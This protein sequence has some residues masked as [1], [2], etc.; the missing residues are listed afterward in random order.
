MDIGEII[1]EATESG[2]KLR[3]EMQAIKEDILA[4]DSQI[5]EL[6]EYTI[7]DEE[8]IQNFLDRHHLE[9]EKSIQ[10]NLNSI[11][12]LGKYILLR[13]EQNKILTKLENRLNEVFN[14]NKTTWKINE[15]FSNSFYF[16][17]TSE[18]GYFETMLIKYKYNSKKDEFKFI[19]AA[20]PVG[21]DVTLEELKMLIEK[22][23]YENNNLCLDK[24]RSDDISFNYNGMEIIIRKV[25]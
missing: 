11:I 5:E 23:S 22:K 18:E 16:S 20:G 17:R 21:W 3:E 19:L 4:N 14:K 10:K 13:D 15:D 9:P 2:N 12:T 8:V 24:A 6:D 25:I 1:K 7:L